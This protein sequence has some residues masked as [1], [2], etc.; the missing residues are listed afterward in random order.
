MKRNIFKFR[1]I[2]LLF[3]ALICLRL[4][5]AAVFAGDE[6]LTVGVPVDRCPVFYKDYDNSEIIGIGADLMRAVAEEAGYKVE[7]KAIESGS[8]KDALD[9]PDFDIVMPFGSA[10]SSTSGKASV[11]SDNLFQTPF[12]LVTTGKSELPPLNQMKVGMLKSLS[13]GAETVRD[14]Y[15]GIQIYFYNDMDGCVKALRKGEVDALLHNSYVWSYVLQ[16]PSYSDLSVQPSTMFSM[17]FRAGA[18]D[19]PE[20]REIISRL[21]SGIAKISDTKRQA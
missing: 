2:A 14:L 10:L 15:P 11:V 17:D 5:P 4:L 1:H 7:F 13:A 9:N 21:N 3:A 6:V 19:T 16:K 12:T 8:L 18:V 20:S